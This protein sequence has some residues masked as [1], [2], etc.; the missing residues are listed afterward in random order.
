VN[1]G[2][3]QLNATDSSQKH[4]NASI[5]NVPSN[6]FSFDFQNDG[7]GGNEL[8]VATLVDGVLASTVNVSGC[9]R[10]W[11]IA[12]LFIDK[13]PDVPFDRNELRL[14][15]EVKRTIGRKIDFD[16]VLDARRTTRKNRDAI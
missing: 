12:R 4:R 11:R 14:V 1:S 10:H 6:Q 13:T 2:L 5:E 7:A 15:L 8:S 3:T 9:R 16:D